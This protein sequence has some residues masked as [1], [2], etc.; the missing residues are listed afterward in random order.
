MAASVDAS[1]TII[2][3]RVN[4]PHSAISRSPRSGEA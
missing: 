4:Q 1:L 2:D 3:R